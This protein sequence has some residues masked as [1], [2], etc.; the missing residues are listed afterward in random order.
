M[1]IMDKELVLSA[2]QETASDELSENV[3]NLGDIEAAR[4]IGF[5]WFNVMCSVVYGGSGTVTIKL[6]THS[7][8]TV[9]AGTAILQTQTFTS[10]AAGDVL[11]SVAIPFDQ[12][13]K[14][15]GLQYIITSFS[16]TGSV[17]AWIGLHPIASPLNVQASMPT[18]TPASPP[19]I[20]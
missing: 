12:L 4:K 19:A 16:S 20:T 17:D 5:V 2:N 18:P 13:L 3:I 10:A 11:M 9:S 14:W 1:T 7:G 6:W 8:T 15:V